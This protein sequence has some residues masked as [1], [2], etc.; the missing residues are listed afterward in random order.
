MHIID[1]LY[2]IDGKTE[3]KISQ[4]NLSKL[5]LSELL[6]LMKGEQDNKIKVV[7]TNTD[8]ERKKKGV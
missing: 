4:Q 5:S 3:L 1:F 2:K 7:V 8:S 6:I